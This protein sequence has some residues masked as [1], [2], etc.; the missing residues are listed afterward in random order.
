M[1]LSLFLA[2]AL[3]MVLIGLWSLR[4]AKELLD[5]IKRIE[6]RLDIITW[7]LAGNIILTAI[8]AVAR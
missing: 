7:L 2:S 4:A 6:R 8:A 5:P 3:I 1:L